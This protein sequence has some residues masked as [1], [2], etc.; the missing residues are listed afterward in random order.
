[1]FASNETRSGEF[2][3]WQQN[4]TLTENQSLVLTSSEYNWLR[5]ISLN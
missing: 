2:E 3:K 1:M 4:I 5:E